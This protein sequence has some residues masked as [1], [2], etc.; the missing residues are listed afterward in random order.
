MKLGILG[1]MA[2]PLEAL[3]VATDFSEDAHHAALRAAMLAREHGAKAALLHVAPELP[4]AVELALKASGAMERALEALTA[5]LE[6]ESGFAFE[7]RL[8]RGPVTDALSAAAAGRDLAVVGARGQHPVRDL[9]L[10]TTAERMVRK[11]P[12][13]VLV[14]KRRPAGAYRRVLVPVDFSDDSAAALAAAA[15]LA[16]GSSLD[17]LHAFEAPF[18]STLR[19]AGAPQAN[20]DRHR[21][22]ARDAA[23]AAMNAMIDK[24]GLA[25]RAARILEHGYAP[26]RITETE[27]RIGADLIAIGKHGK[28]MAEELLLGSVTLHALSAAACDVLVM[29]SPRAGRAGRAAA[30]PASRTRRRAAAPRRRR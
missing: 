29:P 23:R 12:V 16:P 10:G 6:R 4:F 7:P 15:R 20:I 24:L 21:R 28:G 5:E 1:D 3:L 9:A 26:A 22:E 17:L 8:A 13:P 19:L 25:P 14:V 18:E 11:S 27:Q 30:A 2:S